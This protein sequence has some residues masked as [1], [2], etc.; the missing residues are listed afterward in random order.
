MKKKSS[1]AGN[2]FLSQYIYIHTRRMVAERSFVTR[3]RQKASIETVLRHFRNNT[4]FKH[5]IDPRAVYCDAHGPRSGRHTGDGVAVDVDAGGVNGAGVGHV[6]NGG[7]P[8]RA[9]RKWA[10][11]ERRHSLGVSKSKTMTATTSRGS[12]RQFSRI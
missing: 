2:S 4:L 5:C 6:G 1:A 9:E 7:R 8:K 10:R 3:T 12:R 11:Q